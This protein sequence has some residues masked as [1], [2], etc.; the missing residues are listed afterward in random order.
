MKEIRIHGRGGQGAATAGEVLAL[1]AF[2]EGKYAQSFPYFGPERRGA[3]VVTFTRIDDMP[4]RVRTEI[5]HPSCVVVLDPKLVRTVNVVEGLME[6]GIVVLNSVMK[7]SEITIQGKPSKIAAVDATS[8]ALKTIGNPITNM[9][10]LGAFSAATGWVGIK[11]VREAITNR[12]SKD[13][14]EKNVKAAEMAYEKTNVLELK[15]V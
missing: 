10:M 4:I 5:H 3:P 15:V 13:A 7:P 2:Y 12:F 8:I 6:G 14:A 11:A 9:A 1:A